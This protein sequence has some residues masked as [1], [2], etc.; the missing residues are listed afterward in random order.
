LNA[1]ADPPSVMTVVDFDGGGRAFL[2]MTD[3]NP[4]EVKIDQEVEMTFRKL[5]DAEGFS[6]YYWKCRPIR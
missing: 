4:A 2:M 3:R 1:D 5:Y 6:Q